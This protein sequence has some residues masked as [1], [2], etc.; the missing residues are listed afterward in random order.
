MFPDFISPFLSR[1]MFLR[2]QENTPL[3]CSNVSHQEHAPLHFTLKEIFLGHL[4][5]IYHSF[6]VQNIE[7]IKSSR[8][9]ESQLASN[10]ELKKNMGE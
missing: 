7:N 5:W 8:E 4:Q 9:K 6:E 1:C 2:V 3:F 10:Q